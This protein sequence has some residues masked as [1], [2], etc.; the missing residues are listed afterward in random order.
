MGA[1][2]ATLSALTIAA[3]LAA[4]G[5]AWAQSPEVA[6]GLWAQ[7]EQ[8]QAQGRPVDAAEAF[9]RSASAE[10]ACPAPRWKDY[11]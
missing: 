7:A 5:P 4:P 10:R 6:D 8:H 9:V 11:A 2:R 3:L 1:H